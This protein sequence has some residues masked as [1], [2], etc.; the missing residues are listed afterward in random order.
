[1]TPPRLVDG[2]AALALD[3]DGRP[4]RFHAIWLRDNAR[5]PATRDPATGQRQITMLDLPRETWI[6]AAE[7][8][9]GR[10]QLR[11]GPD[12]KRA[13]YDPAWLAAH[14]Y[15]KPAPASTGWTGTLVT[16]WDAAAAQALPIA[17]YGEVRGDPAALR[18]WLA[19]VRRYGFARL[20]GAPVA[21]GIACAVASLFGY[22][23]ETNYGRAFD[24]R[25][26]ARPNNLAYTDRALQPHTDNPYRDPVPGL[27]ILACL[28]SDAPGGETILVDGFMLAK[29][30]QAEDPD[31]FG[32]LAGH[33]ARFAY[34]G[35]H[36]VRLE[37]KK[38]MI[39]LGTD[40]EL[41]AIRFNNRSA[42]PLVDVPYDRM[43]DYYA[44]YRGLAELVE[45]PAYHLS[46][47][48]APGELVLFDNLRILHGREA[49]GPGGGRRLEGCYVD[50]DGLLSTLTALEEARSD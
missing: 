16:R 6:E 50:R 19:M 37:A 22:V 44:A 7:W 39:E 36:G 33:C 34:S 15:D 2:G 31:G 49:F 30:L 32:L 27:Q 14:A 1:M 3:L 17:E 42:A 12:G 21:P 20:R 9:G 47:R 24:V 38:P 18:A 48:L 8:A 13:D 40:G 5:D 41:V 35:A 23:R 28:Q 25:V 43:A 46:F 4:V 10:L 29:Q 26:E 45:A 11:F